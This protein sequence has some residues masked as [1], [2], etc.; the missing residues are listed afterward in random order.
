MKNRNIKILIFLL[1]VLSIT[2]LCGC[3]NFVVIEGIRM[4]DTEAIEITIG[5]FSY[6]G[7]KI[8]D[9][10][11]DG[12]DREIDLTE[13]MIPA[14]E[15]LKFYKI[16]E[17]EI[18]VI[19]ND[20]YV[21]TF[22]VNVQRRVFD[23]VYQL[24][25]Y[26]VTYDGKP[27]RVELNR[28]LPE[29]ATIEFEYGNTF[30]NAG[31][32]EVACVISKEGYVSKRLTTTL[33]IE[34][35]DF[36]QSL[37]GMQDKTYVYDG[38]AK[39]IQV[40]GVPEGISVSYEIY[41]GDIRVNRAIGAGEYRVVAHFT[42]TN[43]NYN[44]VSDLSAKLTIEKADYDMSKVVFRDH[45][46]AYDGTEFV[47][48][49]DPNSVLPQGVTVS[50]S[51]TKDGEKTLS[52]AKVGEYEMTAS[53]NGNT[54]NYNPIPDMTA[55]LTV[56]ER[57]INISNAVSMDDMTVNFDGETHSL[58]LNGTLPQ[59][60]NVTFENNDKIYAGEYDVVARFSTTSANDKVDVE[61]IHAYL[62][63]NQIRGSVKINGQ[64]VTEDDL[65][66]DSDKKTM[67]I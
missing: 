18:K 66:Y 54:V 23:D 9:E 6:E 8:I 40:T 42:A 43:S 4:K 36:D 29:G 5:D 26:T 50:Y 35:A 19:Y 32:Y 44:K 41:D 15:R 13:D 30:T 17:Q 48:Y 27:H 62:I 24:N 51:I 47:P 38:D 52:N 21:T 59:G 10:Y 2:L 64:D 14:A 16:G 57:T 1:V 60:V 67:R 25:G 34:K 49:L 28:E 39:S 22:N 11:A 58:K 12:T 55:K 63:I 61:E 3:G 46:K 31:S 56:F 37:L 33:L 7:K 45:E 53:F 65:Y 20:R